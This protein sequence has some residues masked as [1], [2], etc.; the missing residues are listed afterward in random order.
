MTGPRS[1]RNSSIPTRPPRGGE[2]QR[3][4]DEVGDG[5]EDEI[6]VAADCHRIGT[7]NGPAV[8][9]RG[10]PKRH[11][12]REPGVA[13]ERHEGDRLLFGDR[14]VEFADRID[15]IIEVH[16]AES[17]LTPAL[18]DLGDAQDRRHGIEELIDVGDGLLQHF[19]D[20]CVAGLG[21]EG[22]VEPR[23]E[24]RQGVCAG[25]ARWRRRRL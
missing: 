6:A 2:L 22:A 23:P 1:S 25:R 3:I 20:R 17:A 13:S 18:L 12:A 24:P 15:D 21:V 14:Q 9:P 10:V 16:R 5:L 8:R 11:A 4:V 7:P 19:R